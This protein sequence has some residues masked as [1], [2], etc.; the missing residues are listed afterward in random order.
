MVE[1]VLRYNRSNMNGSLGAFWMY[2]EWHGQEH[3]HGNVDT[4]PDADYDNLVRLVIKSQFPSRAGKYAQKGPS[5][6]TDETMVLWIE[7][8]DYSRHKYQVDISGNAA[9][10][11]LHELRTFLKQLTKRLKAEPV[12]EQGLSP[13]H[14]DQ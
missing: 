9:P 8:P 3:V 4:L 2:Q 6:G 12:G 13:M 14:P 10:P 5:K 11:A 7:Q 1:V